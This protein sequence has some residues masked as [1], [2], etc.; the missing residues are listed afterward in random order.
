[1]C[2]ITEN[3]D[4]VGLFPHDLHAVDALVEVGHFERAVRVFCQ[5]VCLQPPATVAPELT[6]HAVKQ[7]KQRNYL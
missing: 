5:T 3:I 6:V 1:M 2:I 7:P 4:A